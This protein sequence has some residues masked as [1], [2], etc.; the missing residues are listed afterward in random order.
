MT[1]QRGWVDREGVDGGRERRIWE[2]GV[3]MWGQEVKYIKTEI[4]K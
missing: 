4:K 2:Y 3:S 1:E